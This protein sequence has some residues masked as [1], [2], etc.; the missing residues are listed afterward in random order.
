M[1]FICY[2]YDLCSVATRLIDAARRTNTNEFDFF[3]TCLHSYTGKRPSITCDTSLPVQGVSD[4]SVSETS[5]L[6]RS[7]G[8]PLK[9]VCTV[10]V[11]MFVCNVGVALPLLR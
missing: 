11:V 10:F 3:R 4:I 6:R 8:N 1:E 5:K 2:F 7:R 9:L